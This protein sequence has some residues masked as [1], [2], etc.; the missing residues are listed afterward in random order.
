MHWA[1]I[2]YTSNFSW[3]DKLC[4]FVVS[5][6]GPYVWFCT[7]QLHWNSSNLDTTQDMYKFIDKMS[8]GNGLQGIAR[9]AASFWNLLGLRALIYNLDNHLVIQSKM[10]RTSILACTEYRLVPYSRA[11]DLRTLGLTFITPQSSLHSVPFTDISQSFLRR[12]WS[13]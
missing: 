11:C 7:F 6:W 9:W 13:R 1:M 2:K 3:G 12:E 5:L 8:V 10:S 4:F